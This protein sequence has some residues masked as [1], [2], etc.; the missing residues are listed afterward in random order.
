[1]YYFKRL[2]AVVID[3]LILSSVI[4]PLLWINFNKLVQLKNSVPGLFS[5]VFL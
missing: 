4:S 5:N 1:M 3:S 2:F